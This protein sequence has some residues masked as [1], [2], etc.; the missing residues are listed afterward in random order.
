MSTTRLTKLTFF[1]ITI[2]IS[3]KEYYYRK[4]GM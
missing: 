3:G 1:D 2:L 4:A